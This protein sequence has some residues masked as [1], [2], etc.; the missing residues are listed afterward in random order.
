MSYDMDGD[1]VHRLEAYFTLIGEVLHN[2]KRKASFAAYALGLLGE[3]DRK[4]MEPIAARIWG[5]AQHVGCGHQKL[6]YFVSEAEWDDREVRRAAARYAV[7]ALSR[8]E[9]VRTWIID[10]TGFLKQGKHSVGVQ[11]QYTGSAGKTANCQIGV[12]L[13]VATE[14]AHVPIDF[15]L[16]V[17]K[18][19]TEDPER[20]KKA[21]IPDEVEFKTKH[22]LALEMIERAARDGVPGEILL[23]D[24]FYG[25][26]QPFRDAVSLLGFDYGVAIYGSDKM[27][28]VDRNGALCGDLRSAK[29]IGLGLDRNAYRRYTWREGTRGSLSSRFALCRVAVP[30]QHGAPESTLRVEWLVIEWP[31]REE[32]P[33]K[34]VLTTLGEKMRPEEII[35]IIRERYRTERAYEELKGE[36]GL[37]HFEGRSFRG[38]HHHVSVVLCCYAFVVAERTRH[39]LPST[40]R[41]DEYRPLQR[42]A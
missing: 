31:E 20:R 14:H 18:V 2:K 10:D 28:L 33:G 35:R 12:S 5:D 36:L 17:P 6:Q 38:W 37:D 3:G 30:V 11:R 24:S 13:S 15:E 1:S 21:G 41:Q 9:P 16:F 32:E 40:E 23:A 22:E 39:F 7:E 8:D 34:F 19:W 26:S 42:A 4:S 25:H 29:E 27:F